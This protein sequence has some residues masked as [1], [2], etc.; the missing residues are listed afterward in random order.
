MRRI[1]NVISFFLVVTVFSHAQ[2]NPYVLSLEAALKSCLE[3]SLA[4]RQLEGESENERLALRQVEAA[5]GISLKGWGDLSH[6]DTLPYIEAL[7]LQYDTE[8]MQAGLVFGSPSTKVTASGR[9]E[10]KQY[11]W[12]NPETGLNFTIEQMLWDGFLPTGKAQAVVSQ[13]R[14]KYR[15]KLYD[16]EVNRK[17]LL[18]QVQAAFLNVLHYQ[19]VLELRTNTYNKRN[20]ERTR[21]AAYLAISRVT[22]LELRQADLDRDMALK[23]LEYAR[24]QLA[25]EKKKLLLL[26]GLTLES[27]FLVSDVPEPDLPD[28][29]FEQALK[30]AYENRYELKQADLYLAGAAIQARLTESETA[31]IVSAKVEIN[32]SRAWLDKKDSGSVFAGLNISLPFFD[33]D[34]ADTNR[35]SVRNQLEVLKIKKEQTLQN[36][37]LE[38]QGA[39]IGMSDT[40]GRLELAQRNREQLIAR[41]DLAEARFQRALLSRI[42]VLAANLLLTSGEVD[43]LTARNNYQLAV[44]KL[45]QAI[46]E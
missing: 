13:A 12:D 2:A 21:T 16:Y 17:A 29:N 26:T 42:D 37:A 7:P 23:D 46:G 1:L 9:T 22:D 11:N 39:F 40:Y 43:L 20:E 10:I 6:A 28:M 27:D 4:G 36:I 19:R 41:R 18:S 15:G 34:L 14:L 24:A 45:R 38:V 30:K 8:K 25:L 33:S 35:K 3:H 44:V 31:L 32:W 5:N